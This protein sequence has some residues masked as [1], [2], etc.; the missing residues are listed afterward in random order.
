MIPIEIIERKIYLIRGVKVMLDSDLAKLYEVK[1]FN[2][3]KTVKRNINRFPDD[4]MFQLTTQEFKNLRF[5]IGIS[6]HGG[7]RYLP[8]AFTEQGVA[9]LSSI[10]K[11]KRAVRVNI[12]IVRAFV[13][14]R[15]LMA[16]HK[17]LAGKIIDLEKKYGK[18]DKEIQL[19]FQAIK[20][21]LDPSVPKKPKE[22]L[23]F[24]DRNKK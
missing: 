18:H 24:V 22:P 21:L 6:S 4:F 8:L 12:A 19:I 11:S 23:G 10:L 5:Q 20:Q 7:R 13:R 17:E 3:N 16:T 1:T 9:M 14:L 15:E 2:L